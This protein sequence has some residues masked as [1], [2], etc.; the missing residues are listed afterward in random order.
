MFLT[1]P[2]SKSTIRSATHL[3][4]KVQKDVLS[5]AI[6]DHLEV[7]QEHNYKFTWSSIVTSRFMLI[8]W[9]DTMANRVLCAV[10]VF[11]LGRQF[12]PKFYVGGRR[13]C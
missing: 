9:L 1:A 13:S 4:F 12:D 5:G 6:F 11:E 3:N 2:V 7:F 10:A 8:L